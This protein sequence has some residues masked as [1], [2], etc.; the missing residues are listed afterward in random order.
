META[1][2][3]VQ[4]CGLLFGLDTF[5]RGAEALGLR[6]TDYRLHNSQAA[7]GLVK[8]SDEGPLAIAHSRAGL[9][10]SS[11]PCIPVDTLCDFEDLSSRAVE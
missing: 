3:T 2:E 9:R 1:V 7:T 11:I 6:D 5:G 8:G 4:N 10:L